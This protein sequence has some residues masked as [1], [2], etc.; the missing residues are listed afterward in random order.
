MKKN[1]KKLLRQAEEPARIS[2]KLHS[3]YRGKIEII[4]KCRIK[5]FNDFSYW[6][7]PGVAKVCKE[8]YNDP[9][10][11]REYTNKWNTI[12]IVTDGSRV[13]GLGDIGP[14][15]GLPVM[16][17]KALLFKYLGGVDA[18]PVCLDTKDRDTFISAAKLLQP[19]FGGINLE[20]IEQPKCFPILSRLR[21]ECRI[22]V[23]HDDQQGTALVTLAGLINALKIV[24][25]KISN[26]KIALIGA[27]AANIC[28]A[29]LLMLYGAN[30]GKIVMTD[31]RGTLH[32]GRKELRKKYKEKWEMCLKTNR[33]NITGWIPESMENAD[34]VIA[35]SR[36]GPGVIRKEWIRSM[37][38]KPIVFA[39]ANPTPE[40]WPWE[41]KEAG[42]AVFATGRS[43]F[44]N[45]VN[46]SLGFPGVFRGTLDVNAVTIT[47]EMCLEAASEL[48]R[49]AKKLSPSN[50]LPNMDDWD[51]YPRVASAVG[52]KAISQKVAQRKVSRSKL[53]NDARQIISRSRLI[54][55]TMMRKGLIKKAR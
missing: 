55:K 40:I 37:A 6:Y 5:D 21:K 3:F 7:T 52:M 35:L 10:L 14:E 44:A 53:Y 22:P 32:R 39:C 4:P 12:A 1:I 27:G 31:S 15:A 43:D 51:V 48:A 18:F 38:K 19:S 33:E 28:I 16:E 50:I 49:C 17:G 24:G 23:W 13:L 26:V 41:A 8:I 11:V 29:R 47:D 20:D 36:P 25:K 2:K 46:N 54:T 30:P 34:V 45:Q 42:A 9:E